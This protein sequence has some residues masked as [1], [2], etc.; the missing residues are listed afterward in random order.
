MHS[1]Q[2]KE[3]KI[4]C[5]TLSCLLAGVAV[6]D[7]LVW[8]QAYSVQEEHWEGAG[9]GKLV[10]GQ[11][12]GVT[13]CIGSVTDHQ[14]QLTTQQHRTNQYVWDCRSLLGVCK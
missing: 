4:N 11:D 5:S 6:G 7:Q 14:L 9:G 13:R 3:L 8:Q 1:T 10:P 2:Y 12:G